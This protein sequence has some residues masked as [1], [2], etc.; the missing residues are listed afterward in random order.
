MLIRCV[1]DVRNNKR[2]KEQAHQEEEEDEDEEEQ[3][4]RLVAAANMFLTESDEERFA[5]LGFELYATTEK[6][7]SRCRKRISFY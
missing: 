3:E 4:N 2:R 7:S 1:A 5:L 6:R